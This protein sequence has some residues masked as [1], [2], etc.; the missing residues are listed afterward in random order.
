MLNSDFSLDARHAW[1]LFLSAIIRYPRLGTALST[2]LLGSI[3]EATGS[4]RAL[5]WAQA[6]GGQRCKE[7][8]RGSCEETVGV[9]GQAMLSQAPN[10]TGPNWVPRE[11]GQKCCK[12]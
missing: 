5:P 2:S 4:A 7:Q 6:H 1:K 11:P 3:L 12:P 8:V 10:L 9:K